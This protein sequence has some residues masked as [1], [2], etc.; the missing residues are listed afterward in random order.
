MEGQVRKSA[1]LQK[2][3]SCKDDDQQAVMMY[4]LASDIIHGGTM[5]PVLYIGC[6][7]WHRQLSGTGARA[8]RLPT[9]S[10]L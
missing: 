2:L 1:M 5:F 6:S 3:Q 9:I 8:P 10:F 4:K 7:Q